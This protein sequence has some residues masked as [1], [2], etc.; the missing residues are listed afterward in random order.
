MICISFCF[1]L[2]IVSCVLHDSIFH[3]LTLVSMSHS[4]ETVASILGP[5]GSILADMDLQP[6]ADVDLKDK[7]LTAST[8]DITTPSQKVEVIHSKQ[9]TEYPPSAEPYMWNLEG[10]RTETP[11]PATDSDDGFLICANM[12]KWPP[13]TAA[14]IT[15]ITKDM[16]EEVTTLHQWSTVEGLDG[17]Q[18][19][20]HN[21]SLS[22]K[23][24]PEAGQNQASTE[25]RSSKQDKG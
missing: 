14:D 5:S 12:K 24:Q 11:S 13:L 17:G 23:H 7:N 16:G 20:G 10:R 8:V 19:S 9:T 1:S 21:E 18:G 3:S 2:K 6:K 4:Y 22:A 15:E 25:S